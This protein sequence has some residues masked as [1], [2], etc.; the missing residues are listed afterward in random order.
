MSD[1]LYKCERFVLAYLYNIIIFCN[2][3]EEHLDNLNKVL[4]NIRALN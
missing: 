3:W 4:E 2:I 1:L